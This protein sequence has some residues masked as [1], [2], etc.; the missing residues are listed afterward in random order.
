MTAE[1]MQR[2]QA[3]PGYDN[4]QSPE[5]KLLLSIEMGVML[6]E[7]KKIKPGARVFYHLLFIDASYSASR[8]R[9]KIPDLA[10]FLIP[11]GSNRRIMA[12]IFS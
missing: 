6:Q 8:Y 11:M 4:T 10:S 9:A 5:S 3:W 2:I 7:F 12:S 1:G